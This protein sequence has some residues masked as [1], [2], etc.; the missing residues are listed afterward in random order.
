MSIIVVVSEPYREANVLE[1]IV[2]YALRVPVESLSENISDI[3]YISYG[4][5]DLTPRHMI[6]SFYNVKN[7]LNKRDGKQ[8]HHFFLSIYKR[9]YRGVKNKEQ[10]ADILS[11]YVGQYLRTLGFQNISFIHVNEYA[12][13]VHI[14]FVM[15]SVNAITGLKLNNEKSFYNDLLSYLRT[16]FKILKWEFVTYD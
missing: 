7:L 6:N 12:S 4:V 15:N 3:K 1:N 8:I 5:N 13:N 2:A 11:S 16:N 10:W 14:H 9:N